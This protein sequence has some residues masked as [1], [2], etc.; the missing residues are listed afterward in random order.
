[1]AIYERSPTL[2]SVQRE[3]KRQA[4][5]AQKASARNASRTFSGISVSGVTTAA[6]K[7]VF[8]DDLSFML[9]DSGMIEVYAAFDGTIGA[10]QTMDLNMRIDGTNF[11]FIRWTGSVTSQ[12]RFSTPADFDGNTATRGGFQVRNENIAAGFHTLN[13]RF[14]V[15]GG[16]GSASS[17][18]VS[19]RFS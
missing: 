14:T 19:F 9:D 18:V 6:P 13:F 7:S 8:T 1:M 3:L 15:S 2:L 5:V 16:T 10:G 11:R 4:A 12:R 17:G